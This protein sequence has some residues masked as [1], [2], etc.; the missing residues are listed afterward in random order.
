ML[1]GDKIITADVFR[2]ELLNRIHF[3]PSDTSHFSL[4]ARFSMW[5]S[6]ISVD[7]ERTVIECPKCT[8]FRF[9]H[10][11]PLVISEMPLVH[12]RKHGIWF[13]T[14]CYSRDLDIASLNTLTARAVMEKCE[15][16]FLSP[17]NTLRITISLWNSIHFLVYLHW[18]CW[19]QTVPSELQI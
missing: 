5:W 11:E 6:D 10:H 7:I 16:V 19:I 12:R 8:E 13:L 15:S 2:T 17:W 14:H 3:E 4:R 18:E 1:K 9:E